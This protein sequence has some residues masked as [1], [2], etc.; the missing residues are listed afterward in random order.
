ME[1]VLKE[2]KPQ[3]RGIES[4]HVFQQTWGST[5][6]PFGGMGGAA[7]TE[8]NVCMVWSPPLNTWRCYVGPRLYRTYD[9]TKGREIVEKQRVR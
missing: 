9:A 2:G 3:H 8:F 5:A 1:A 4:F 7:M 6:G